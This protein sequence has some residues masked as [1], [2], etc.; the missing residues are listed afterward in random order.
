MYTSG[1]T[2]RPKGAVLTHRNLLM[3][4]FSQV[5]HLGWHPEDRVAVAGAPLFHIAGARGRAA[6]AAGGR[7]QRDHAG[8]APSTRSRPST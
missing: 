4:V 8:P 3:H 2:G 1:T 6:A 7:H 5:T